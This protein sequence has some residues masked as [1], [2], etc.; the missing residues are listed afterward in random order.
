VAVHDGITPFTVH[1]VFTEPVRCRSATSDIGP[2]LYLNNLALV[3]LRCPT[4]LTCVL[5]VTPLAVDAVSEV[6]ITEADITSALDESVIRFTTM[7]SAATLRLD[8]LVG[9]GSA[10][11][12]VRPVDPWTA[13]RVDWT[14]DGGAFP[15]F[16]SFSRAVRGFNTSMVR[17]W[18]GEVY[19]PAVAVSSN[20]TVQIHE[21]PL[22]P[23]PPLQTESGD[24]FAAETTWL[25]FLL[26]IFKTS[27]PGVGDNGIRVQVLGGAARSEAHDIATAPSSVATFSFAAALGAVYASAYVPTAYN[28]TEAIELSPAIAVSGV[29]VCYN[30]RKRDR[31]PAAYLCGGMNLTI[32]AT[33]GSGSGVTGIG[34]NSTAGVATVN[35]WSEA[36]CSDHDQR[37][38]HWQGTV[39]AVSRFFLRLAASVDAGF[40]TGPTVWG[41]A[42]PAAP[43]PTPLITEWSHAAINHTTPP[44][45]MSA[46]MCVGF[47]VDDWGVNSSICDVNDTLTLRVA[48]RERG[49]PA[50]HW[51][52]GA[53]DAFN[54]PRFVGNVA[55]LT[56]VRR[57]P[58]V[59]PVML[60]SEDATRALFEDG[61]SVPSPSRWNE[62]RN[63]TLP[64][65]LWLPCGDGTLPVVDDVPG[66]FTVN[67]YR[68]MGVYNANLAAPLNTTATT[69]FFDATDVV[70]RAWN[71]TAPR[72]GFVA[73]VLGITGQRLLDLPIVSDVTFDNMV[74][75]QGVRGATR[76]IIASMTVDAESTKPGRAWFSP[77]LPGVVGGRA[78]TGAPLSPSLYRE[79]VRISISTN[80]SATEF[81]NTVSGHVDPVPSLG[82]YIPAVDTSGPRLNVQVGVSLT[83]ETAR[84][85]HLLTVVTIG[86]PIPEA[87][88]Q[89]TAG[90]DRAALD[91]MCATIS[92]SYIDDVLA[93]ITLDGPPSG[94]DIAVAIFWNGG[95]Y[96]NTTVGAGYLADAAPVRFPFYP[97]ARGSGVFMGNGAFGVSPAGTPACDT[98]ADGDVATQA[99]AVYEL[100]A[101]PLDLMSCM[102]YGGTPAVARTEDP[103]NRTGVSF[104]IVVTRYALTL[105]DGYPAV[106]LFS[107]V[108]RSVSVVVDTVVGPRGNASFAVWSAPMFTEFPVYV[109]LARSSKE[110]CEARDCVGEGQAPGFSCDCGGTCPQNASFARYVQVLDVVIPG[111]P[112]GDVGILS[113][114]LPR[115]SEFWSPYGVESRV[116]FASVRFSRMDFM[117]KFTVRYATR[118]L[119]EYNATAGTNSRFAF[120]SAPDCPTCFGVEVQLMRAPAWPITWS[121]VANGSVSTE[122][123]VLAA[124]AMVL[125]VNA[126]A[127]MPVASTILL[128]ATEEGG[129]AYVA[130]PTRHLWPASGVSG[131]GQLGDTEVADD[132]VLVIAINDTGYRA[133]LSLFVH[134]VAACEV[135]PLSPYAEC[136]AG[137]LGV[138]RFPSLVPQVDCPV[139]QLWRSCDPAAWEPYTTV[140]SP[141]PVL[142]W[143]P[144]VRAFLP[145]EGSGTNGSD[146]C[147]L[148]LLDQRLWDFAG[149]EAFMC[150][151]NR[152]ASYCGSANDT[153]AAISSITGDDPGVDAVRVRSR[154]VNMVNPVIL[155]DV[156][157]S[158]C[159]VGGGRR[160]ALAFQIVN[161]T[162]RVFD[163]YGTVMAYPETVVFVYGDPSSRI[164]SG[165]AT[166]A[167]AVFWT[168]MSLAILC[169]L[170]VACGWYGFDVVRRRRSSET[171]Y[172]RVSTGT[173]GDWDKKRTVN[174]VQDWK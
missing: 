172:G 83:P 45:G 35:G 12:T 137:S 50:G 32:T 123:L 49:L 67:L 80:F 2:C 155:V 16:V 17:V 53:P 170:C 112:N 76:V 154:D 84:R 159:T 100:R 33:S 104:Q 148:R 6:V 116:G 150:P 117:N 7:T 9:P 103:S 8:L 77:S 114:A 111:D 164:S 86:E 135:N 10:S 94:V 138:T 51:V 130:P 72:S 161:G 152:A 163:E 102:T 122:A 160:L 90:P 40:I 101:T 46:T 29:S 21:P 157:V 66:T 162:V 147:R 54:Q 63:L 96:P 119:S 43:A 98:A 31:S 4:Q 85:Q 61:A 82:V 74:C 168:L 27:L 65:V 62:Y 133:S 58:R 95:E 126:P 149:E 36:N 145:V 174:N 167:D 55:G 142:S 128:G 139:P 153:W 19:G 70:P 121:D 64:L 120:N 1:F 110:S 52:D 48:V 124:D 125:R 11:V 60:L 73:D 56:F 81:V 3:D 156:T 97:S 42:S 115:A 71:A 59:S 173:D 99:C 79:D 166:V 107:S 69:T 37:E 113:S 151:D 118:C 136:V 171:E 129:P 109:S 23:L 20:A 144:L 108:R 146:L 57:R 68:A 5:T 26:P 134:S 38:R 41:G 47:T 165:S 91:G 24:T 169:V 93:G 75:G 44:G 30:R 140:L 28:G 141:S 25:L 15:V 105:V 18:G 13:S 106:S 143:K 127:V 131:M 158:T 92:S 78:C 14:H 39:S 87:A 88:F 89:A 22:P 34:M 132:V